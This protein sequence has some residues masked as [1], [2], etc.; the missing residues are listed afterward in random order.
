[1]VLQGNQYTDWVVEPLIIT[2][3]HRP[4]REGVTHPNATS[5][6]SRRSRRGRRGCADCAGIAYFD[7]YGQPGCWQ[8]AVEIGTEQRSWRRMTIEW[9]HELLKIL[10][11][12]KK[13]FI[14]SLEGA[15]YDD[16]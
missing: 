14:R 2:A 1:M 9:V 6:R 11:E 12:R 10:Q 16:A 15:R 4:D 7:V 13:T 8:D 3:R 5:R